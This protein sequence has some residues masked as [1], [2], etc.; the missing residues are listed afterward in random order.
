MEK[1][2]KK[3]SKKAKTWIIVG[4]I[5]GGIALFYVAPGIIAGNIVFEKLFG[6]RQSVTA[7]LDKPPLHAI[8]S[9]EDFPELATRE[10]VTFPANGNNLTA[11]LYNATSDKGLILACHGMGG[12]ADDNSAAYQAHFVSQGYAVFALDMTASGIS[13][14][15]RWEKGLR[16]GTYD[17]LAAENYIKS[18]PDLANL[19]LALLGHSVGAYGAISS[20]AVNQDPFAVI[21]FSA[22]EQPNSFMIDMAVKSVGAWAYATVPT[23]DLVDLSRYGTDSFITTTDVMEKHPDTPFFLMHDRQDELVDYKKCSAALPASKAN[24][25]NVNITIREGAGH[26]NPWLTYEGAEKVRLAK[27]L[28]KRLKKGE[29]TQE[30][31]DALAVSYKEATKEVDPELFTAIDSFLETHRPI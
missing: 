30:E 10:Y 27:G 5:V 18:R 8:A 1:E 3:L 14:G 11:R 24:L 28:Q 26:S 29:I 21:A 17:I 23:F 13:E 6:I 7:D 9:W 19:P 2:K 20:I 22:F 12:Q 4:S 16:Q 25:E 15:Q 31:Y